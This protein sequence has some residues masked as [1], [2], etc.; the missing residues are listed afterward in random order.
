MA[1][2]IDKAT[3]HLMARFVS[4]L[5]AGLSAELAAQEAD[6][7]GNYPLPDAEVYITA[8]DK[9]A[10]V[11][12]RQNVD[13]VAVWI[14]QD[15]PAQTVTQFSGS[16]SKDANDQDTFIKV[17]MVAREREA[18]D[19]LPSTLP[20]GTSQGRK[21]SFAE[22]TAMRAHLYK[23]AIINTVTRDLPDPN[24]AGE[25]ELEDNQ[26]QAQ[27]LDGLS[28]RFALA[29]VTFKVGQDVLIER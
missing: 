18:A 16:P 27:Q 21:L 9:A 20:D 8:R 7:T 2:D 5:K 25:V 3:P 26:A 1:I 28:G 13:E 17:G 6:A 19:P 22:W 11:F 24:V 12:R 23:G 29:S 4:V 14:T 15:G 10:E